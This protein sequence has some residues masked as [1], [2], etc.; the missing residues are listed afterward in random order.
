MEKEKEKNK[1]EYKSI[2]I[3]LHPDGYWEF[4]EDLEEYETI[5]LYPDGTWRYA[6][7]F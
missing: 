1:K 4:E 2:K 7:D 6:C 5:I 3:I